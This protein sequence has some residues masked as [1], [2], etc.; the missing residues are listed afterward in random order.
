MS[1][2]DAIRERHQPKWG[3]DWLPDIKQA[4]KS[5]H[6]EADRASY[7]AG[8]LDGWGSAS[9]DTRRVLDAL[10]E[11]RA[12]A[13]QHWLSLLQTIEQRDAALAREKALAE[14]LRKH[15]DAFYTIEETGYAYLTYT[16][17][18]DI[19]P[20]RIALAAHDAAMSDG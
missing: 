10:D 4:W 9:E 16:G 8:F 17:S 14:A 15:I 7:E 2:L 3:D 20:L 12:K 5:N 13:V 1:D 11:A 18:P 19:R 6:P